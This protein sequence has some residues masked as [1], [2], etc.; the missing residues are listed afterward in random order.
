MKMIVKT[1]LKRRWYL[2]ALLALITLLMNIV[3]W[4]ESSRYIR[5]LPYLQQLE[6]YTKK[7]YYELHSP[8]DLKRGEA[9]EDLVTV[10]TENFLEHDPIVVYQ[11]RTTQNDYMV[12]GLLQD[13]LHEVTLEDLKT[14]LIEDFNPSFLNGLL[15][16]GISPSQ[17]KNFEE[18]ALNMG[19]LLELRSLKDIYQEE[20]AYFQSNLLFAAVVA[21]FAL[22]F[23]F[24]LILMILSAAMRI[25][26]D[27]IRSLRVIGMPSLHIRRA[28]LLSLLLPILLALGGFACFVVLMRVQLIAADIIIS[29]L[30]NALLVLLFSW[31]INYR[32]KGVLYA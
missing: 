6:I 11:N 5:A 25:C 26:K 12:E 14:N 21:G 19:Y 20:V 10:I 9:I 3:F 1:L 2:F 16:V 32:L 29:L 7:D 24:F 8:V 28:F 27:D 17:A 22:V 23:S 30:P 18:L 13:E 15:I 31:Q 4:N